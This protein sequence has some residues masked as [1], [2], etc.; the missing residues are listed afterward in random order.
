MKKSIKVISTIIV[1]FGGIILH[2]FRLIK[3]I[4]SYG[5]NLHDL[6]LPLTILAFYAMFVTF[7]VFFLIWV[8][9]E[10]ESKKK[11][12]KTKE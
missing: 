8:W 9:N 7:A 10:D 6:F 12:I 3:E 1:V 11:I 4:N 5:G 2:Y